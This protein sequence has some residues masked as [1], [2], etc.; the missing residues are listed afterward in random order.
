MS[1]NKMPLWKKIIIVLCSL[2]IIAALILTG[3]V[4]RFVE[5]NIQGVPVSE[6]EYDFQDFEKLHIGN[7]TRYDNDGLLDS[8]TSDGVKVTIG[9]TAW[10][11]ETDID[12]T[13]KYFGELLCVLSYENNNDGDPNKGEQGQLWIFSPNE[14]QYRNAYNAFVNDPSTEM[15]G[16]DDFKPYKALTTGPRARFKGDSLEYGEAIYIIANER[17][18]CFKFANDKIFEKYRKYDNKKQKEMANQTFSKFDKRCKSI[19]N[20]FD[21]ASYPSYN[22]YK[23]LEQKQKEDRYKWQLIFCGSIIFLSILIFLL[24][25]KKVGCEN[26]NARRFAIYCIICFVLAVIGSILGILITK[27]D[28]NYHAFD[29]IT[30]IIG[31]FVSSVVF[32]SI[33]GHFLTLRSNEEYENFWIIPEWVKK[34]FGLRKEFKKRLVAVI[35]FY[36]LFTATPLPLGFVFFVLYIIP[37]TI[38]YLLGYVI[39]WIVYGKK[40]DSQNALESIDNPLYCRFCGKPI[41]KGSSY[42]PHCGKKL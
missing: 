14:Y 38:L 22:K 3:Y 37:V 6:F 26:R 21:L 32:C 8:M 35:L 29:N 34:Q 19:I 40:I 18:Y 23:E 36:P 39:F 4:K 28:D 1:D 20:N 25:L 17:I 27:I 13:N 12:F 33:I 30:G 5:Y 7:I 31:C 9:K 16:T 11:Y 42:C 41:E 15:I 24:S 2:M 10:Y